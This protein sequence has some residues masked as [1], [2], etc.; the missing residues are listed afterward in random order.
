MPL[1]EEGIDGLILTGLR[2]YSLV[3]SSQEV[4]LCCI[5]KICFRDSSRSLD[6]VDGSAT[7]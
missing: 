7:A 3:V 5:N 4:A 2:L 1:N 6:I